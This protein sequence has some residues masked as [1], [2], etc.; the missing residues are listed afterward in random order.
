MRN[1]TDSTLSTLSS[2]VRAAIDLALDEQRLVGVVVL[3]ARDGT[4]VH[5][6]AD[7]FADRETQRP[8][9]EDVIFRFSSVTK[10]IVSAAGSGLAAR[11]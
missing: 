1:Y 11:C 7:G 2:R 4:I 5:R 9:R 3:I 10:P 8:M 6:S